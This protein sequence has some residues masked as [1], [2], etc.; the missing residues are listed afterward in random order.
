MSEM[1]QFSCNDDQEKI[2]VPKM[3]EILFLNI[4][5]LAQRHE[6]FF[7]NPVSPDSL[8]AQRLFGEYDD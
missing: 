5:F 4:W 8:L 7:Q 2:L 6:V 1:R 3:Q